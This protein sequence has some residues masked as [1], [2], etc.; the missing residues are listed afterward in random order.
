MKRALACALIIAL[1]APALAQDRRPEGRD[2][3]RSEQRRGYADPSAVIA[4]ELAFNRLAQD[5]G[6]WTAFLETSAPE[7]VMFVPQRVKAA[8]WLKGRANPAVSVTWQPQSVWT[9]CDG[10]FAVT[11]G[12]WQQAA[13]GSTGYF[14]TIWERQRKRGGK[15]GGWK[16][17]LDHGHALSAPLTAPEMIASRTA[18]CGKVADAIVPGVMASGGAVLD[19]VVGTSNDGSLVWNS[20]VSPDGA[21]EL[22]VWMSHDGKLEV[23]LKDIVSAPSPGG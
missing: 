19:D 20:S 15:H 12:A 1:A 7:A 16:W 18:D 8:Q 9:S 17:V 3:E 4:A 22:T 2:R 11:H 13:D 5:K 6:Q 23:V 14:T 10:G 21:R